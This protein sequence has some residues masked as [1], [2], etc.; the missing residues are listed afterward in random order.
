M[1]IS[2]KIFKRNEDIA[3]RVIEGEALIV[4]TRKGL[5]YPLNG[6]ATRIWES[7]DGRKKCGEIAASISEE[8]ECGRDDIAGDVASFIEEG[9]KSGVIIPC[10]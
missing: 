6:T 1:N 2:D 3:W 4:D 10:D 8:F 5:I 7:L 9:I